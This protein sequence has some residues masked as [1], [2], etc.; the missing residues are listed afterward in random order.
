MKKLLAVSAFAVF[1]FTSVA[2]A[3][4]LME[5]MPPA[6]IATESP[7]MQDHF[8]IIGALGIA[9]LRAGDSTIGVTSSETDKLVQTNT[10]SWNTFG[11]QLGLGYV[12]YLR[13]VP[14]YPCDAQWF[15]YLEPEL[16]AYYLGSNSIK[17][18]VW[19]FG[20]PSFNQLTYDISVHSVRLML[21]AALDIVSYKKLSLYAIGGLGGAW[22]RIGYS[23]SDKGISCPDQRLDL[24]TEGHTTFAW[25]LGGGLAYYFNDRIGLSLEYL[26]ADLGHVRTSASGNTGTIT[27]PVIVPASF[28]LKA[29]N[30]LLGLHVTL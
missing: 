21:D 20:S 15:R 16:N 8:E 2:F 30:V 18:D 5:T 14:E 27:A 9:N 4:G 23:D 3:G 13:D 28:K 11:A 7:T 17:G 22:S 29:H 10:N 25:E 26:Y 12:A 24:D 19:R 6:P 1:G